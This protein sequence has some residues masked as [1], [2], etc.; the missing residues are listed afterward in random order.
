MVDIRPKYLSWTKYRAGPTPITR[1]PTMNSTLRLDCIASISRMNTKAMAA[2]R[3]KVNTVQATEP[4]VMACR[5]NFKGFDLTSRRVYQQNGITMVKPQA[6]V[7][8][9]S[10]T[11]PMPLLMRRP[12][13]STPVAPC[14]SPQVPRETAVTTRSEE[15][16]SEL[17]SLRHLVCR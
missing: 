9:S 10:M 8:F 4:Q 16:T 3:E 11:P 5:R 14:H 15:H 1:M 13:C 6:K 17:Q 7:L 12:P 2:P